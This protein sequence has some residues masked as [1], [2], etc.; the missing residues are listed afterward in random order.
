M[1]AKLCLDIPVILPEIPDAADAC[2]D[3]L[4]GEL[5]GRPGIEQV[6]VVKGTEPNA[7]AQLCVHYDPDTLSLARIN[8]IVIGAGARL[9]ESYG[10][11]ALNVDGIG[12]QRRARSVAEQLL[13]VKGV[14]E[15]EASAAGTVRIEFDRSALSEEAL[16][17]FLGQIGI[18]ERPKRGPKPRAAGLDRGT[19]EPATGDAHT[20][21][22]AHDH[23]GD[24]EHGDAEG[25]HGHAHGGIFGANSELIFAL[26]C[27]ALL[28]IGFAIEK[29]VPAPAW[30]PI[31]LFVGA[32]GFGGYFTMREAIDNLRLK[33]FE[34]D[35]LMLVAAA[36]AAALG[37]WAE[38]ALLLF[39]FSLG[40]ALEHYAMGR[41]KRAIEALAELA[42]D[43]ALVRRGDEQS[44]IPVEELQIGDT[45]IV[46]PDE[47]IAADGFLIKGTSSVNQ[48]PVTGESMPVDKRPVMDHPAASAA[49]DTVEAANRVFA[50][51]INGS[52]L[53][54][55]EVTRKS[56][57]SALAKVVKM[58]SEA[59]TQ[60]SPTQRFTDRFERIFVP[61]VLALTVALLFA[62]VIVDE[63]FRDSFYRAMA[64]LVAA[65]PCALAIATPSAV[66]SGVA[67]AARGGVLVKGGGPLENLGSLNAIAFDKTGTLTEG[68][69]QITDV[70]PAEGVEE[71]E[72]VAIAVAVEKLSNHPLARAI[73]RDGAERLGER[74]IPT[75][76]DLGSLT[77][78]GVTA[79]IDG[80]QITI[81]KAEMFGSD[82]VAPLSPEMADAIAK[83]REGGRT[84]MVVRRGDKDLGA[85]GLMDTPRE[86]AKATLARLRE[87]GITRMIMISGDNQKVAEAIASEVGI[88]EAI[89]D[90]M[91]E[92][93]VDAIK[94]LRGEGKVAMVGDGVNDAPAMANATVGIAMGAAGSDVAL[95]TADVALMADDL[96][97]LPFAVGLSRS[98][99][100]II[101]QNVFV[102]L[103]VVAVLVPATILGL[104]IG[105]AVAAHEGSTLVVVFNALRLL[106]YKDRGA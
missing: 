60:R 90:L 35:T 69:P 96:A 14:Q 74:P 40:H 100:R 13:R 103:G 62:W 97:H 64:V 9:T 10:H 38:G 3:R 76:T 59:E 94:R 7:P 75:A 47:R 32:Y 48:A 42:P 52:G 17:S 25:G 101:R 15:A 93:K 55:I 11:L 19:A 22:E 24:H 105:P 106:A 98:T 37:A 71:E 102:S 61:S 70:I 92:D 86:A 33:R 30:L 54:E 12:H 104:G 34:I 68:R 16:R 27:G 57:D 89:G 41:A 1:S 67:R 31:A 65:S 56:T 44:E 20:P 21:G 28:G 58:V 88:D 6:H 39:L 85:I 53:I 5:A 77:G 63:P 82:G 36:G 99:R 50:G 26:L 49:P 8:D 2:V 73:A 81:G 79:R 84:T 51:T 83:L 95:E 72:L 87:L 46:K 91:P 45:V 23:D 66:L 78:R 43:T 29:L 4:K 80:D 18:H